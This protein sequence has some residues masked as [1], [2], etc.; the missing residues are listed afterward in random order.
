MSGRHIIY[1]YANGTTID[2][3]IMGRVPSCLADGSSYGVL[4]TTYAAFP[5][6]SFYWDTGNFR[7]PLD[8]T[9]ISCPTEGFYAFS[10]YFTLTFSTPPT[11]GYAIVEIVTNLSVII[12]R[13]R[14]DAPAPMDVAETITGAHT[15]PTASWVSFYCDNQTDQDLNF[16]VRTHVIRL[17]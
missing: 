13:W 8:D 5:L 12:S 6:Q 3:P 16:Y 4:T 7:D 10:A 1:P 11:T 17:G 15:I 2:L 14:L 9:I